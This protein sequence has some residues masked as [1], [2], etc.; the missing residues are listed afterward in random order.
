MKQETPIHI[1]SLGAGVQSSTLALMAARGEITPMPTAAIF[2]DTQAEPDAVYKWIGWL[3]R[4]LPFPILQVSKGDLGKDVGEVRL[5]KRSGNN[6]MKGII[7]AFT[8][9]E[10]TYVVCDNCGTP[11]SNSIC[12]KCGS[13]R[14]RVIKQEVKGIL[15]RSCTM[16]YKVAPLIKKART[17]CGWK[18]GEK[19]SLV[20]MWIGIS[21]DEA[22]R[23][24]PSREL[25]IENTFPLIDAG[26]NRQDC[27]NWMK[28]NGFPEPP[29]SACVFCPF[30]SDSEWRR[31]KTESPK[32]FEIAV[33]IERKL[34]NRKQLVPA[35][36]GVPFL[37]SSCKPLSCC[38][39]EKSLPSHQQINMFGNECE[40]LCGV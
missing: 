25:W 32:E 37:H 16:D 2:A 13:D 4:N 33:E 40:G 35:L 38:D 27:L 7:P 15:G 8:K 6:Y 14:C 1:L 22:H 30:H 36:N 20:K 9:G 21:I 5:S 17:L 34:Q 19:R 29:R 11:V 31:L 23:M 3:T 18:R 24:K 10:K 26:M 39:F 28:K 12:E